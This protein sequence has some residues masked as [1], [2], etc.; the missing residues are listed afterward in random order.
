G[1]LLFKRNIIYQ[2]HGLVSLRGD[3]VNNKLLYLIEKLT[4]FLSTK[5]YSV[6]ESLRQ[7]A[8]KNNYCKPSKIVTINNGT[9]NGIDF[10][11]KFNRDLLIKNQIR[12]IP[13]DTFVIGFLGRVSQDKGI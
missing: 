12:E 9:I 7:A 10:D 11:K 2:M 8:I 6:S 4:C 5:I 1:R 3:K 13:Q